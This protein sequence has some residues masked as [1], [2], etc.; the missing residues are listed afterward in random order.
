MTRELHHDVVVTQ[1]PTPDDEGNGMQSIIRAFIKNPVAAFE[2]I[3]MIGGGYGLYYALN[4][5]VDDAKA[6]SEQHY[7]DLSAENTRNN[8]RLLAK[9]ESLAASD[10]SEVADIKALYGRGDQRWS[11]MSD[12][13][14]GIEVR[15]TK[16]EDK[17]DYVIQLVQQQQRQLIPHDQ[18]GEIGPRPRIAG[19][20]DR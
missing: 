20:S 19:D 17:I 18:R 13:L 11:L 8:E 14:S 2:I 3:G 16:A 15:F 6:S 9:L 10:A 5:K 4:Y 12:K 1:A 7:K